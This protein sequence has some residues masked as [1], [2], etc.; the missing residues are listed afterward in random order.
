[1]SKSNYHDFL[2]FLPDALLEIEFDRQTVT[3]INRVASILLGYTQQD[4][5]KGLKIEQLF[6]PASFQKAIDVTTRYGGESYYKKLPYQRLGGYEIVEYR[7]VRKDGTEL[8]VEAQ[9]SMVLDEN[10]IASGMRFIIRDVSKRKQQTRLIEIQ[11]QLAL[12]LNSTTDMAEGLLYCLDAAIELSDLDCGGV[13]L[14]DQESQAL[15]LVN[16]RGLSDNFIKNASFYPL[17]TE[18]GQ[19]VLKGKPIYTLH[20]EVVQRTE[21]GK[22]AEKLM[23]IAVIPITHQQTVQGCLNIASHTKAKIETEERKLMEIIASRTG[24]AIAY[25]RSKQALVHE[26]EYFRNFMESLSDWVWESDADGYHTYSNNAVEKILGYTADEIVGMRISDI[27]FKKDRNNKN[28]D[29]LEND[30]RKGE[31]WINYPGRC[32]HKDG[33][34]VITESTAIPIFNSQD[35]LIGYRG[36]D[37]DVTERIHT[38]RELIK[39]HKTLKKL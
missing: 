34:E 7:M 38:E 26:T 35:E 33:R 6:T 37:R 14:L 31:A 2:E 16:H 3:Y 5:D 18:H 11:H 4:C 29:W 8:D 32:R 25:L 30:Y 10:S 13:Y 28:M 17:D 24:D 1:M 27:W 9:G 19:L 22:P 15:T 36:V 39:S 21:S 20:Q 12:Q 23:A